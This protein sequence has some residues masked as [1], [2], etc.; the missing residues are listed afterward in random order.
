MTF[1]C[2]VNL[3]E[4]NDGP[5]HPFGLFSFFYCLECKPFG[6]SRARGEWRLLS[7]PNPDERKS[8][9]VRD[10]TLQSLAIKPCDAEIE[11]VRSLPD[12]DSLGARYR[13]AFKQIAGAG[14]ERT[15]EAYA[16]IV[17]RIFGDSPDEIFT[18]VGGYPRWIQSD[19]TPFC[20]RC[21]ES[22]ELLLQVASEER[23][24][25][26]WAD[27]GCAYLFF[28]RNHPSRIEL[29]LQCY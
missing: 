13:R 1:I 3:G 7:F 11:V 19:E 12:W 8:V 25:I 17:E 21:G 5:R 20:R 27:M 28:C 18:Q 6:G 14:A 29:R 15:S 26:M 23:A 10:T 24:G 22:M 9:P 4:C 16:G 2:Q